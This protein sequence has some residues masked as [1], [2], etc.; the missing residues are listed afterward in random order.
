M[1]LD[2]ELLE[3]CRAKDCSIPDNIQQLNV[4]LCEKCEQYFKSKILPNM[5]KKDAKAV[6]DRTFN[7]WDSFTRMAIKEGGN[8]ALLG[9]LF[10]QYT[11]KK[12]LLSNDEMARIYGSL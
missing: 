3:M 1:F 8:M 6:M 5:L 9:E 7:L 2:N 4:E 11:F 10:Q 12:Q